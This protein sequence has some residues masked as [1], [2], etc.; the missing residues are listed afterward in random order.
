VAII[1]GNGLGDLMNL[2]NLAEY[3]ML[4]SPSFGFFW[5]RGVIAE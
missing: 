2:I 4:A 5:E 1:Q 3:D